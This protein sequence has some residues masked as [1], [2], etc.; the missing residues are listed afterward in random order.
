V[1][2]TRRTTADTRPHTARVYPLSGILCC[3]ECGIGFRGDHHPT[4]GRHYYQPAT[5]HDRTC[6]QKRTIKADMLESDFAALFADLTLPDDWRKTILEMMEA[7]IVAQQ[8]APRPQPVAEMSPAQQERLRRARDLYL[9][10]DL[11][12][13]EYQEQKAAVQQQAQQASAAPV[14]PVAP[15]FTMSDCEE[16]LEMIQN[17]GQLYQLADLEQ[18]KRL[19]QAVLEKAFISNGEIVAIQPRWAFYPL[20]VSGN[21]DNS[22]LVRTRRDSGKKVAGKSRRYSV[23]KP[24][25][26]S[27]NSTTP[28]QQG[29][30]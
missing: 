14:L 27:R 8:P 6:G 19:F 16:A 30:Q 25:T 20:F 24:G 7:E 11:T 9:A 17:F 18:R 3:Q 1:R 15:P 29:L 28:A 22:L 4:G 23:I 5:A 12:D 26:N 10:G 21:D 2:E 13:A